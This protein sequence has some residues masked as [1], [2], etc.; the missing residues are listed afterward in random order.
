MRWQS[1]LIQLG[2]KECLVPA[3]DKAADYD[4]NKLRAV[5]ER[6]NAIVTERKK[7]ARTC[8]WSLDDLRY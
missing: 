6:C 3:D 8:I 7:G 1:F 4:L 5:I 2:V